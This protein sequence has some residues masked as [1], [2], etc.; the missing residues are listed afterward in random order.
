[1]GRV[2]GR[3]G[4]V[5]GGMSVVLRRGRVWRRG[6]RGSRYSRRQDGSWGS[7]LGD[8]HACHLAHQLRHRGYNWKHL[9]S[10]LGSTNI[11]ATARHHR[12]LLSLRQRRRHL[13]SNLKTHRLNF[14]ISTKIKSW[15]EEL[16]RIFITLGRE[17]RSMSTIAASRYS[18]HASAF[19][20]ICSASAL[21]F[22]SIANASASPR[23]LTDSASASA[24]RMTRCLLASASFSSL[25]KEETSTIMK[26]RCQIRF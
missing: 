14:R 5:R 25:H 26:L 13:G 22:A 19:F 2:G 10:Q 12:N 18:F 1:M 17:S 20:D 21:A 6:R 8:V 11:T 4:S 16:F 23:I 15:K 7:Y 3:V 9:A 24:S